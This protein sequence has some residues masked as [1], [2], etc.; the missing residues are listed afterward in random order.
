LRHHLIVRA[1]DGILVI[2]RHWQADD[3]SLGANLP[4]PER[5][6]EGGIGASRPLP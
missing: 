5:G 1:I 3:G 2:K 6:R 4:V